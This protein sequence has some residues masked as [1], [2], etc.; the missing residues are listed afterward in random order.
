ML[1]YG[2]FWGI[3]PEVLCLSYVV[4]LLLAFGKIATVVF[5]LTRV[6]IT[7]RSEKEFLFL[8]NIIKICC[9]MILGE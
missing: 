3:C 4:A 9:H 8:Y 5:M 2:V 7:T 1:G 6:Y